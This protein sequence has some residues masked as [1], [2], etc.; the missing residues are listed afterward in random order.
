MNQQYNELMRLHGELKY[1]SKETER[2]LDQAN[3]T[4]LDMQLCLSQ[5]RIKLNVS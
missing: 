1:K 5:Y 2:K 3:D 4:I